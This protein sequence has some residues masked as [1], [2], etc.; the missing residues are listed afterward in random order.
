MVQSEE[1][2]LTDLNTDFNETILGSLEFG[3]R[4]QSQYIDNQLQM[5]GSILNFIICSY[6]HS[7]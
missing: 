5:S 7:L 6:I 4:S 1:N 3:Q 2:N